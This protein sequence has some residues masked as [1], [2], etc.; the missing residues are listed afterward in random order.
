MLFVASMLVCLSF[1]AALLLSQVT[2]VGAVT[3]GALRAVRTDKAANAG[4]ARAY[5]QLEALLYPDPNGPITLAGLQALPPLP[6][7]DPL[8]ADGID[9]SSWRLLAT[10][11][12]TG[13]DNQTARLGVTC[14]P[15]CQ[16]DP[17]AIV[18]FLVRSLGTL[19]GNNRALLEA[20]LQPTGN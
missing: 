7:R 15:D 16:T 1:G 18:N 11:V 3:G 4:L 10:N 12:A 13:N 8:C 14:K 2:G 5:D 17:G 19:D 6:Q 9:C 20:T